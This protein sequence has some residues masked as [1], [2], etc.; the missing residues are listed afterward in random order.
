LKVA[1]STLARTIHN[2]KTESQDAYT[3]VLPNYG[4]EEIGH[5][6]GGGEDIPMAVF[7]AKSCSRW[8]YRSPSV[9][10]YDVSAILAGLTG[11]KKLLIYVPELDAKIDTP[12]TEIQLRYKI[13]EKVRAP[14]AA[15]Q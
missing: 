8:V 9:G 4:E 14:K 5:T 15:T 10:P 12:H 7:I 3:L 6:W 13:L 2:L 1:E 11:V